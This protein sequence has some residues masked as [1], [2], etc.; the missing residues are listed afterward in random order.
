M[1]ILPIY[2]STRD[3]LRVTTNIS[4][5]MTF[6]YKSLNFIDLVLESGGTG[7]IPL[8]LNN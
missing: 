8:G 6:I 4:D 1:N 3:A 2:Q 7:K 5:S